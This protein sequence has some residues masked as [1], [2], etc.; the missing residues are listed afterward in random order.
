M[1]AHKTPWKGEDSFTVKWS[2]LI[3]QKLPQTDEL[4]VEEYYAKKIILDNFY[5]S[6]RRLI[7]DDM[8]WYF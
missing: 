2:Y 4:G 6:L 5:S 7:I 8:T 3:P 1:F